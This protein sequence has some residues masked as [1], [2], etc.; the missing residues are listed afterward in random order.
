MMDA[1]RILQ[2]MRA[3]SNDEGLSLTVPIADTALPTNA[4]LAVKWNTEQAKALFRMLKNDEPLS[5]PPE[6]TVID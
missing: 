4:G 3:M 1:V 6:G 5:V 2:A